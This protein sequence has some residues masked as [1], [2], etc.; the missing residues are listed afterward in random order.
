[1]SSNREQSRGKGAGNLSIEQ[2][3]AEIQASCPELIVIEP[4]EA[5]GDTW[6]IWHRGDSGI[7]AQSRGE[8]IAEFW[9]RL[10]GAEAMAETRIPFYGNTECAL[11]NESLRDRPSFRKPTI[12]GEMLVCEKCSSAPIASVGGDETEA[13][14]L[15]TRSLLRVSF[16]IKQAWVN[17]NEE[18]RASLDEAQGI[19][20]SVVENYTCAAACA[21]ESA[22]TATEPALE[23]KPWRTGYTAKELTAVFPRGGQW[24]IMD[25]YG[26]NISDATY[27]SAEAAWKGFDAIHK[28]NWKGSAP[29]QAEPVLGESEK[30]PGN[31]FVMASEYAG[32]TFEQAAAVACSLVNCGWRGPKTPIGSAMQA[33]YA[34]MVD[35]MATSLEDIMR[36]S[37][38]VEDEEWAQLHD[39]AAAALA[40]YREM[41]LEK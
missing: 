4:G 39:A 41:G 30:V 16:L 23:D 36:S 26:F 17:A 11:C 8:A 31:E 20:I 14:R 25:P 29:K 34:A 37:N 35:R 18:V 2:K 22:P 5:N 19:V 7:R 1:M 3:L 40:A 15:M 6:R 9:Q 12:L 10:Q 38:P 21:L 27:S 33:K 32:V 28:S 24:G 13:R